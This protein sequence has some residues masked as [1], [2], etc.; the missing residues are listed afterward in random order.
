M[1]QPPPDLARL[2]CALDDLLPGAVVVSRRAYIYSTS[3]W[4][5]PRTVWGKNVGQAAERLA[6]IVP[7]E[8]S[9]LRDAV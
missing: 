8:D 6:R 7:S 2:R 4:W 5:S 3:F 9:H 1:G